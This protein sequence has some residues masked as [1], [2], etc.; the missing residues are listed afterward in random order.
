MDGRSTA[1]SPERCSSCEPPAMS[2]RALLLLVALGLV[3]LLLPGCADDAL[4]TIGLDKQVCEGNFPTA[5]GAVARCVLDTGHYL[6][7]N[8]PTSQR[9]IVRT[10]GEA[11][12]NF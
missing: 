6:T 2:G 9:F 7:G 4:F 3:P 5:C 1:T 10:D 11:T 8:F 12:V